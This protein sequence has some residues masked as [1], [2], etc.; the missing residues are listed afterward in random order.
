METL[1][2][3]DGGWTRLVH[4]NM[5]NP[6]KNCPDELRLYDDAEIRG[7]GRP[8]SGDGSCQSVL[9]SSH[10]V[11]YSQICGRAKG[12]QYYSTDAV[13][14]SIG[15]G[16][17]DINSHYVDG[18]SITRGNPRKHVW[19]FMAGLKEDNSYNGGMFT[20][21][22]QDG[23]E[24]K[25]N[26]PTFIGKDYYCESGNPVQPTGFA[27]I[28]YTD[29]PLWDGESCRDFEQPCCNVTNLPWF[30]KPLGKTTTDYIEVRVCGDQGTGDEDVAIE[31][32]E[33][34]V[35]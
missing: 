20:C 2:D 9:Y 13:D 30:Y 34:Y 26:I 1:C 28:L 24:Q 10:G 33:I 18:V 3:S 27:G 4:V 15:T 29:D 8:I 14:A 7:C 23:S 6:L 17:N 32:L 5:T 19:T 31:Q 22:C 11:K 12:Y 25:S 16:H 35:K 21:P